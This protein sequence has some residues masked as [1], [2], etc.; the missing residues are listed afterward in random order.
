MVQV[1]AW[2]KVS[3]SPVS[4]NKPIVVAFACDSSSTENVGQKN[5][6]LRSP[7]RKI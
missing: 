2:Q 1:Q 5:H 7:L 3:K 4:M 6:S